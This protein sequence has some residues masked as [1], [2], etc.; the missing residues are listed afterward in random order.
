MG[1]VHLLRF[2]DKNGK[3]QRLMS[4]IKRSSFHLWHLCRFL[5][6]RVCYCFCIW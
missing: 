2:S 6:E 1:I 5:S 3:R 4:T